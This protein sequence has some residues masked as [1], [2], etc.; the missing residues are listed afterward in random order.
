MSGRVWSLGADTIV[1]VTS[2]PY[3]SG[4]TP[5]CYGHRED[6]DG[7]DAYGCTFGRGPWTIVGR[8]RVFVRGTV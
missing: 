6:G 2:L 3:V 7:D 4:T 5:E 8:Y 1:V